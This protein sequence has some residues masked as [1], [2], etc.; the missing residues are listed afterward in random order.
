ISS[1]VI[2]LSSLYQY[3]A[4]TRRAYHNQSIIEAESLLSAQSGPNIFKASLYDHDD[5]HRHRLVLLQSFLIYLPLSVLLLFTLY[6]EI[7]QDSQVSLFLVILTAIV[8]TLVTIRYL[9][10]TQ[11]NEALLRER[12]RQHQ[13]AEHLRLLAAQLNEML[14][15]D[16]LLER[17]VTV[18]T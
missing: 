7:M 18:A 11:Q 14:E 8:G 13:V 15:F 1:L 4:I 3:L 5:V 16:P 2:G 12:K 17:I 9:Y 10:A 6:S